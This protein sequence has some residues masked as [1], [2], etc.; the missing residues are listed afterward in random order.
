MNALH[1][2][3]EGTPVAVVEYDTAADR[4]SLVYEPSWRARADAFPV[5][6]AL[7]L[8]GEHPV[9]A[10][11]RFLENLLPEGRALDV[12]S[13][14][15]QVSRNN[16][17][18]LLAGLGRETVGALSFHVDPEARAVTGPSRALSTDELRG[19]IAERGRVPFEVWDGR[20]RLP[21]PGFQDKL[22]VHADDHGQLFLPEP[23]DVSTYLLKPERLEPRLAHL[24]ANEHLCMRLAADLGLPVAS[25]AIWRLPDPV[26]VIQRF[27]RRRE[28]ARWRKVHII[29]GCQAT[30]TGLAGKY[31]RN[32]G[33]GKDVRHIRD[34]VSL[35]KLLAA[36]EAHAV[37]KARTKL[38]V[39]RWALFQFLIGNSDAHGKNMS[40]FVTPAGLAPAP[41]YDLVSVVQFPGFD[42]QLSM[43]IGDEF[44]LKKVRAY[45]W[46]VLAERAGLPRALIGQRC[47]SWRPLLR[48]SLSNSRSLTS[49]P[50]TSGRWS[51]RS[52]RSSLGRQHGW[53]ITR[54][55]CRQCG[56]ERDSREDFGAGQMPFEG[57]RALHDWRIPRST[58]G[59]KAC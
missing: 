46:A 29:D 38:T 27:D 20:V 21:A 15:L 51:E 56:S 2:F 7:P 37:D 13:Q 58:K 9:G 39:L 4:F 32:F 44:D 31:E 42:Q 23:P 12:A 24:V 26:L 34:G 10:A 25:A 11:R 55:C 43:A 45:D 40:F 36:C 53:P 33:A 54:S 57:H 30:D 22:A 28:G 48:R 16:I 18:G 59:I 35:P 47:A 41:W 50:M 19:R 17:Y 52:R 3:Y 8:S 1:V 5:S 6:N 14:S 49:T